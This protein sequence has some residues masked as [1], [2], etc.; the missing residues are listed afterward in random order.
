VLCCISWFIEATIIDLVCHRLASY[1]SFKLLR[2][3]SLLNLKN[4]TKELIWKDLTRSM[5]FI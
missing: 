2:R 1:R 3:G 4:L 5:K